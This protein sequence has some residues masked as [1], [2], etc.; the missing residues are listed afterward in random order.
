MELDALVVPCYMT[1]GFSKSLPDDLLG[2]NFGPRRMPAFRILGQYIYLDID[3][4]ARF[5]RTEIRDRI[6]VRDDRDRDLIAG[7]CATVRE[8]PSI[9]SEPCGTTYLSRPAGSAMI[10]CQ[11]SAFARR[12]K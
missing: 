10:N 4:V 12:L 8:I 9:A 11:S 1:D 6:G 5:Q 3:Y 2:G 7:D